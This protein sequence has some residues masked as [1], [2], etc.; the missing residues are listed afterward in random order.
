[1]PDMDGVQF[2][3]SLQWED[4]RFLGI[5]I[6]LTTAEREGSDLLEAARALGVAAVVHKPW[7]PQDLRDT[8]RSVVTAHRPA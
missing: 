6:V 8:I 7:K 5:P 4:P 2:I 3:E 1:M